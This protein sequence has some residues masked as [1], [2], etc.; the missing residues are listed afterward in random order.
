VP[1][2]TSVGGFPSDGPLPAVTD[3]S[4][5]SPAEAADGASS[6][7]SNQYRTETAAESPAAAK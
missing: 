4:D 1:T 2:S 6:A 5:G 3:D 7:G